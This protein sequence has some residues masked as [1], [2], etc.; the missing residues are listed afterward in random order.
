M[1]GQGVHLRRTY[2]ETML[3]LVEARNYATYRHATERE[4]YPSDILLKTA[5]ESLRVTA[6]LLQVMAWVLAWTAVDAGEL[7]AAQAT[8]LFAL[9]VDGACA[10]LSGQDDDALPRGLRNLLDR[11]LGLY[12]R[13]SRLDEQL[14][15][16]H[17]ADH[18]DAASPADRSSIDEW[19]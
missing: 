8:A 7:T 18:S 17:P 16:I 19:T 9:P 5:C 1:T 4:T 2:D 13:V 11:S 6:R 15:R 10:E 14:R 12:H 3:L